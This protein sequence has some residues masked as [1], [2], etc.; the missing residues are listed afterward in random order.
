MKE[1][2]LAA[3]PEFE[4]IKGTKGVVL[5]FNIDDALLSASKHDSDSDAMTLISSH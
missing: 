2:L 5:T 1:K 4:E 3:I